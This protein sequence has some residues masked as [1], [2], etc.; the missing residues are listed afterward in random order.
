ML[1]KHWTLLEELGGIVPRASLEMRFPSVA[2]LF[3]Q[4]W[5]RMSVGRRRCASAA[6][7]ERMEGCC[8]CPCGRRGEQEG[9]VGGGCLC[10]R[11]SVCALDAAGLLP[12]LALS[13][14]RHL[15]LLKSAVCQ[16]W[17]SQG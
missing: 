9:G 13:G 8:R 1:Q 10:W 12:A 11:S 17:K 16:G 14:A 7:A 4:C 5:E 6:P 2:V 3:E 15:R